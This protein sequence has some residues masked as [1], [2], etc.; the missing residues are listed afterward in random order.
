MAIPAPPRTDDPRERE[1]WFLEIYNYTIAA[2]SKVSV[3]DSKAVSNS[4]NLSVANSRI[5]SAHP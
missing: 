5:D 2:D 3:A 1:E 4:T